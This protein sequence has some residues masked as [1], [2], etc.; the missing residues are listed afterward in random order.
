METTEIDFKYYYQSLGFLSSIAFA[1]Q[2]LPQM[3]LNYQRKSTQGFSSSGIIIKL[4]GASFLLVNSWLTGETLPIFFYGLINV[5]QHSTFMYQFSIYDKNTKYLLW[6]LFPFLPLLMGRLY[7]KSMYTT[8]SIKPITQVLSHL[9]QLIVS[10]KS[11]STQGVSLQSQYLNF[12]GG[13][14]GVLML[15]GIPPVSIM[16]YFIYINSI[17]QSVSIFLMYFYYDLRKRN[18][19][20]TRDSVI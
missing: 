19:T 9:P 10:Y 7:P 12:F 6:I 20:I 11:K 14:V 8:N 3:K 16:T 13:V 15:I 18:K 2:Y 5:V 1:I 4:I 17:A